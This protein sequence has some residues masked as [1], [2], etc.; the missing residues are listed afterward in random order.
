MANKYTSIGGQALIEGIMMKGPK[1]TTVAVRLPDGSID[2]SEPKELHLKEKCKLL[3]WPIIRGV[4][5]LIE[6]MTVGYRALMTSAEKS[7]FA[8]EEGITEEDKKKESGFMA[9]AMVIGSVLGVLLAVVLFMYIPSLLCKWCDA[10]LGGFIL[11]HNLKAL[12]EG[13]LKIMVFLGYMAAVSLMKDIRRVFMYHGA[14]HKTIFCYEAKKELTVENVRNFKRFH[15]RCGTSF[16]FL[17]L[18]VSILV[19]SI[20]TAVLPKAVITNNLL[21]V[22]MKIL[23]I[24]VVCGFGYELIRLCGRYDNVVTR[25]ISAPGLWVQRL[26]TKE[27]ADDMIEVAI[28]ALKEVLPEESDG[29]IV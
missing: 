25:I 20:L 9:A 16:I 1:K 7:G 21:W 17:V 23:L 13:I 10:A 6:S 8:E 5:T 28:A 12:F 19:T 11:A 26:T 3:G 14:E 18:I 2:L 27:P 4:T 24:P 15:P 29:E 22:P